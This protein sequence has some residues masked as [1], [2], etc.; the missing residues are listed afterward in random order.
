MK[1]LK[2]LI[3]TFPFFVF[4][5]FVQAENLP[6]IMK[7]DL[8]SMGGR[9]PPIQIGDN[10]KLEMD[11]DFSATPQIPFTVGCLFAT[12]SPA[13]K[14]DHATIYY[15]KYTGLNTNTSFSGTNNFFYQFTLNNPPPP[16]PIGFVGPHVINKGKFIVV[17]EGDK[18]LN[19]DGK[20]DRDDFFCVCTVTP[21]P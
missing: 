5:P 11:Y 17:N 13:K 3:I 2:S 20:L 19:K 21:R 15:T 16:A 14:L 10:S 9:T 8:P 1:I 6:K 12:D 7:I 4:I 18:H